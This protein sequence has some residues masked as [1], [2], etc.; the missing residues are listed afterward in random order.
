MK[1][2]GISSVTTGTETLQAAQVRNETGKFMDMVKSLQNEKKGDIG[3]NLAGSQVLEEGRL[4]GDYNSGF[5]GTYTAEADKKARPEGAAANSAVS[6]N[7]KTIDRTSKL[8]EKSLELE[9][10][11]VK[12]LLSSMRKTVQKAD[13]QQDYA[14]SMYEDMLYDEYAT[15]MTKNAHFGL[16]DEIY[17]QLV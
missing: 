17:M 7:L 16:A 8:Y 14:Q 5:S 2:G 4:N 3:K 11:F 1:I 12:M 13:G 15:T 10:Y 9:S 6:Q